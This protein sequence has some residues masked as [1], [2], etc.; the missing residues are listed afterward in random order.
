MRVFN[1]KNWI[2]RDYSQARKH[3]SSHLDHLDAPRRN[4]FRAPVRELAG[5]A[6]I[7]LPSSGQTRRLGCALR[8]T[9]HLRK[10]Q[11]TGIASLQHPDLGQ[12][13]NL[14]RSPLRSLPLM[15][16]NSRAPKN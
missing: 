2:I 1:G 3:K 16:S 11:L 13:A 9:H 4:L 7:D 5:A 8:E 14:L 6:A 10:L 15:P 12:S